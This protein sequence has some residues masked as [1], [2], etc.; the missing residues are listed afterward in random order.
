MVP[1]RDGSVGGVVTSHSTLDSLCG[2]SLLGA[3]WCRLS[4]QGVAKVTSRL[5]PVPT[6]LWAWWPLSLGDAFFLPGPALQLFGE[7]LPLASLLH[8]GGAWGKASSCQGSSL[9]SRGGVEGAVGARQPSGWLP[10]APGATDCG[11]R[12]PQWPRGVS[13]AGGAHTRPGICARRKGTEAAA[14]K[15][16][17]G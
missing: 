13:P 16:A 1:G 7:P 2:L 6:G 17:S 12:A 11:C 5:R 10:C 15:A 9:S 8:S 3:G 4:P 14:G